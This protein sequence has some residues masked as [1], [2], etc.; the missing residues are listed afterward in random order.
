MTHCKYCGNAVDGDVTNCPTCGAQ[1]EPQEGKTINVTIDLNGITEVLNQTNE[2]LKDITEALGQDSEPDTQPLGYIPPVKSY[3]VPSIICAVL[4]IS[5]FGLV[6]FIYG[7]LVKTRVKTGDAAGA[8]KASK[9]ARL[10]MWIGYIVGVIV[11]YLIG[12]NR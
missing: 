4:F 10:W 1:I 3:I 2:D 5:P 9:R 11:Y 6:A 8:M 12:T 7:I